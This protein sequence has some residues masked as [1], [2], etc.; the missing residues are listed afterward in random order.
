MNVPSLR[1]QVAV[2]LL[3]LRE[4]G[5]L[6]HRDARLRLMQEIWAQAEEFIALGNPPTRICSTCGGVGISLIHSKCPTC[7]GSGYVM[8]VL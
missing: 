1:E 7:N 2:T 3:G 6:G 5:Y 4:R 8:R